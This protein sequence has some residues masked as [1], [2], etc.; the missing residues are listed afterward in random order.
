[1]IV[2]VS[3]S[4]RIREA[5][6]VAFTQNGAGCGDVNAGEPIPEQPACAR[7][8]HNRSAVGRQILVI[9]PRGAFFGG[10]RSAGRCSE[11]ALAKVRL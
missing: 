3:M 9:G 4:V 11:G 8:G 1:M 2:T 5:E 10:P 7:L 6:I